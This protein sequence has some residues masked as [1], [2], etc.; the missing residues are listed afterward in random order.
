MLKIADIDFANKLIE[1][2]HG[3]GERARSVNAGAKCFKALAA[4]LETR[5]DCQET[6][7][8][9]VRKNVALANDGLR[10]LLH[11]VMQAALIPTT[12]KAVLPHGFRHN[13]ASAM[14]RNGCDMTRL[15][16]FLGHG[17]QST[18]EI[19]LHVDAE[20]M[21]EV[22]EYTERKTVAP[23]P[24]DPPTPTT[25]PQEEKPDKPMI[26]MIDGGKQN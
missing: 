3:K 15:M 10:T 26:Y 18:T 25:P 8:F 5:P 9:L 20:S 13:C 23:P 24:P 14:H 22:G 6:R 7:V 17:H 4:Y 16:S 1:V 19:Y 12:C 21:K 11:E 2:R